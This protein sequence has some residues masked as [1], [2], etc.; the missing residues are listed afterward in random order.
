[1]FILTFPSVRE[2]SWGSEGTTWQCWEVKNCR[3]NPRIKIAT[4][5]MVRVA[6]AL[7]PGTDVVMPW[8]SVCVLDSP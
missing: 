2:C 4:Y 8:L 3:D 7:G 5:G 1:M 6:D